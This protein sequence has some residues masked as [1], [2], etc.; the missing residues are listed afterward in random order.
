MAD[1]PQVPTTPAAPAASTPV[2]APVAAPAVSAAPVVESVAPVVA[3]TPAAPVAAPE[4]APVKSVETSVL[5]AEPVAEKPA[6]A[7]KVETP[8]PEGEVKVEPKTE[9]EKPAELPAYEAF[10][11]PEG[12]TPDAKVMGDFTKML[13][14]FEASKPDHAKFQE[15]GQKALDFHLARLKEQAQ[16]M[17]DF[18]AQTRDRQNSEEFEALR[19]DPVIGK[20]DDKAFV[21]YKNDMANFLQANGGTKEEVSAF[22]K[23]VE[24]RKVGNALPIVRV[25]HNL[26]TKIESL[27]KESS[28][29][30]AGTKPV[31]AQPAH[32][33]LGIINKLYGGGK[34][35]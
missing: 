12:V 35:A 24:D 19:K 17:T 21:A 8:K 22:K 20:G 23:F 30:V 31:P 25:L 1:A 18:F 3:E 27:T 9:G 11:I 7:P 26:K 16:A 6:E 29:I 34:R 32:P 33:G 15:F 13:S 28:N 10:K 4:S 2:A 5:G 14:E